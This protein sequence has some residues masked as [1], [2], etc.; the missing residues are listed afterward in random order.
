[1][2]SSLKRTFSPS[3]LCFD[4]GWI[5]HQQASPR[6]SIIAQLKNIF[7]SFYLVRLLLSQHQKR[8]CHWMYLSKD[9]S[10]TKNRQ[11]FCW[12]MT[13]QIRQERERETEENSLRLPSDCDNVEEEQHDRIIKSEM[14]FVL[15]DLPT[16]REKTKNSCSPFNVHP[17]H[18]FGRSC[19]DHFLECSNRDSLFEYEYTWCQVRTTNLIE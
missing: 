11:E 12:N 3:L 17:S 16:T 14:L 6:R 13:E 8:A 1:M 19:V 7:R 15:L 10:S 18:L 9:N 4:A 2:T 5:V